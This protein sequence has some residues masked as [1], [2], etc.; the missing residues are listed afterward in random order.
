[1]PFPM[2]RKAAGI[3]PYVPGEQPAQGRYIKLN[4]NENPYPPSPKAVQAIARAAQGPLGLYPPPGCEA[5]KAAIAQVE[6]VRPDQVFV[7]N[8]SDEVL[9]MIF[10]AFFDPGSP[11]AFPDVTYSFYPVYAHLYGI[12]FRAIPLRE[13]W[14]LDLAAM[15]DFPGDLIFPNPNAPTACYAPLEDVQQLLRARA[16]RM[17][18]VDEAYIAFGGQSAT[19]LLDQYENLLVVRTLS[20]SHALAGLRVGY[21]IGSPACISALERVKNSFN[22]YTLDQL[23]LAGAT[24]AVLD[25]DY[26][27]A[28]CQR[29]VA[30]RTWFSQRLLQMGF[31]MPAS[32]ANFVFPR[33]RDHPGAE[34]FARLREGGVLVRHFAA[35]RT[36]DHLRITIGTDADMHQVAELLGRIVG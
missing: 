16:G 26:T 25:V 30:T 28:N 17:V 22:S 10:L 4:T 2:S 11:I 24:A 15:R 5:L 35:K 31:E 1:M 3:T 9:A 21:A 34:L 18:V 36:E 7:G 27:R 8:G 12:D 32:M 14:R 29:I 13:D 33:H 19:A 6:G 23:A 20:K